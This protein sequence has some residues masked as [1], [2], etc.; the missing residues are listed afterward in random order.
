[1]Q[2]AQEESLKAEILMDSIEIKMDSEHKK[3]KKAEKSAEHSEHED[4]TKSIEFTE[5]NLTSD[6][7]KKKKRGWWNKLVN[8]TE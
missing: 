2:R 1:M 8:T 3:T 6:E 4:A 5:Q 7:P